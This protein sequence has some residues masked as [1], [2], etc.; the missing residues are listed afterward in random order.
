LLSSL[1]TTADSKPTKPRMA[2]T[3]TAPTPGTK[4]LSGENAAKL[5]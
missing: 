3:S 2:S 5:T 1:K 4:R